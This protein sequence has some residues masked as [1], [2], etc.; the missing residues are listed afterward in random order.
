M[1]SFR[2]HDEGTTL[3]E[4]RA[5]VLARWCPEPAKPTA[6][7]LLTEARRNVLKNKSQFFDSRL[8]F[9]RLS[10]SKQ[11]EVRVMH[12]GCQL[13]EPVRDDQIPELDEARV[14]VATSALHSQSP[15]RRASPAGHR[16]DAHH[17]QEEGLAGQGLAK[18]I[19]APVPVRFMVLPESSGTCDDGA[20]DTRHA[21]APAPPPCP[22][23]HPPL[24]SRAATASRRR[25]SALENPAFWGAVAAAAEVAA[26]G[27]DGDGDADGGGS[28]DEP[29]LVPIPPWE[30]RLAAA[31]AACRSEPGPSRGESPQPLSR[32]RF[33]R[34]HLLEVKGS[35][36]LGGL[37]TGTCADAGVEGEGAG[38]D[39]IQRPPSP[40][41]PRR[42]NP[43]VSANRR[44]SVDMISLAMANRSAPVQSASRHPQPSTDA[45]APT[46]S[47]AASNMGMT[48]SRPSTAATGGP[49]AMRRGLSI[50]VPEGP[51]PSV[52][53]PGSRPAY[54][55]QTAA[56]DEG[57]VE[58]D[59][60]PAGEWD[61]F[62]VRSASCTAAPLV[63]SSARPG[64]AYPQA[65]AGALRPS[66]LARRGLSHGLS[67][68]LAQGFSSGLTT[69][70]PAC[71]SQSSPRGLSPAVSSGLASA[72][73]GATPTASRRVLKSM[74]S[75]SQGPLGA[76][77]AAAADAAL[78]LERG[79][80]HGTPSPLAP[81][82][83][84]H[85][86]GT[87]GDAGATWVG[88][89]PSA[90][91]MPSPHAT[92]TG[93]LGAGPGPGHGGLHGWVN[94]GGGGGGGAAVERSATSF[95]GPS[96]AAAMRLGSRT[97]GG[98]GSASMGTRRR[99]AESG[100]DG[101]SPAEGGGAG[102]GTA[103]AGAGAG[104]HL[105]FESGALGLERDAMRVRS[106][107]GLAPSLDLG[108]SAAA[109]GPAVSSLRAAAASRRSLDEAWLESYAAA[110]HARVE[111]FRQ[112]L[113]TEDGA[114]GGVGVAAGAG[115]AR[116]KKGRR[117]TEEEADREEAGVLTR[118][119]TKL[120]SLRRT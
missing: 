66:A 105:A 81:H 32:S 102:A 96:G 16:R 100:L 61:T 14:R 33:D 91:L 15:G 65:G 86:A 35:G 11:S 19:V 3:D 113:A 119:M 7:D 21:H 68:G 48:S 37:A 43:A 31:A 103:G 101:A 114:Q 69:P 79:E 49:R 104:S 74:S 23:P 52:A 73:P 50:S 94:S 25:R 87:D 54:A 84:A 57:D 71:A 41:G 17:D 118:L 34:S 13:P 107:R 64:A 30:A 29:D 38:T 45:S 28:G 36:G 10:L 109:A 112:A 8:A 93:A 85:D 39:A 72:S 55:G 97:I 51:N 83:H 44:R 12:D 108:A 82:P 99:A 106:R 117:A 80:T 111:M 46:P 115:E 88:R 110:S 56:E 27:A 58:E 53:V 59:V 6:E 116:G 4:Y 77:R 18:Y 75:R 90:A 26:H 5:E 98:L 92:P 2:W 63:P 67:H 47:T 22:S 60:G 70:S 78:A 89:V 40:G 62:V 9:S 95:S 120:Q 76:A 42:P 1:S 24:A 20:E